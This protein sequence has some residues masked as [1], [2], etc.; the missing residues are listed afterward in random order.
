VE[1]EDVVVR[2]LPVVSRADDEFFLL[3]TGFV[4]RPQSVQF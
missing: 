1:W 2:P 3:I 4:S